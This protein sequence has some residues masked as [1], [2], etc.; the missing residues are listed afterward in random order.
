M[1]SKFSSLLNVSSL[2]FEI[3]DLRGGESGLVSK[4]RQYTRIQIK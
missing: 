2:I 3:E 1:N 4:R